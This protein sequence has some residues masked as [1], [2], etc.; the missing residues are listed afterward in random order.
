MN[1]KDRVICP[2]CG[3]RMPILIASGA[4]AKGLIV[5]CKG[6]RCGKTFEIV[7]PQK[8]RSE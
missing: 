5:K 8:S 2:H 3:Y 4:V 6:R 7:I 1:E